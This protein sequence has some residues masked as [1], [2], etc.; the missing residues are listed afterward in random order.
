MQFARAANDF[1]RR[2]TDAVAISTMVPL[3]CAAPPVGK[4]RMIVDAA[5]GIDEDRVLLGCTWVA[6]S[7][8]EVLKAVVAVP[9]PAVTG[10]DSDD[11]SEA[12]DEITP[13]EKDRDAEPEVCDCVNEVGTGAAVTVTTTVLSTTE[14]ERMTDVDSGIEALAVSE[15]DEEEATVEEVGKD[16]VAEV[17]ESGRPPDP[18]TADEDDNADETDGVEVA[19]NSALE[20]ALTEAVEDTATEVEEFV[21]EDEPPATA[22]FPRCGVGTNVEFGLGGGRP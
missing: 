9:L 6:V 19:E 11:G 2:D 13:D 18:S 7:C 3:V 1:V 22:P 21:P 4:L 16:S 20:V 8:V 14:V 17:V 10:T 12:E 15:I 5:G